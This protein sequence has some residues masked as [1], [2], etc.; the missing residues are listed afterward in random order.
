MSYAQYAAPGDARMEARQQFRKCG[1]IIV[2]SESSIL[3]CLCP[4]YPCLLLMS[5]SLYM[6]IHVVNLHSQFGMYY[7]IINRRYR[8]ADIGLNQSTE[9]LLYH[10]R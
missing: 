1:N 4:S 10:F 7:L 5:C 2:G 8:A 6:I 3:H 9:C